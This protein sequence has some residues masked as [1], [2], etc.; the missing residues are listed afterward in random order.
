[1]RGVGRLRT[2]SGAA[3]NV[4]VVSRGIDTGIIF[5]ATIG[6]GNQG[7]GSES[8]SSFGRTKT[9]AGARRVDGKRNGRSG[10]VGEGIVI[11]LG[12][13]VGRRIEVNWTLMLMHGSF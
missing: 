1:M 2:S 7:G 12:C 5:V 4:A 9:G 6:F 3:L 10:V 8:V 13:V 11:L